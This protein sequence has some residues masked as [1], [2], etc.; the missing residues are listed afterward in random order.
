MI[1]A[2]NYSNYELFDNVLTPPKDIFTTIH[3]PPFYARF[4]HVA[5][6]LN[7]PR[8]FVLF[9]VFGEK[10]HPSTELTAGA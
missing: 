6:D 1:I 3:H 2:Q 4:P 5:R 10:L 8:K 7:I 9:I